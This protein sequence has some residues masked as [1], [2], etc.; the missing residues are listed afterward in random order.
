[1]K[2]LT[3]IDPV[4]FDGSRMA[5][6]PTFNWGNRVSNSPPNIGFPGW[7][8]INTTKDFSA[9]VTRVQGRHTLK[10]GYYHTHSFKAEQT[11]T[12]AASIPSA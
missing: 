6:V 7:L 12:A 8:N 11:S 1:M 2:A 10:A 5:K 3:E 4:F 9:S